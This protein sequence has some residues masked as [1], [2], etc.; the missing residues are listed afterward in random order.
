[1]VYKLGFGYND[2]SPYLRSRYTL[3]VRSENSTD[4]KEG[5]ANSVPPDKY[6]EVS[7]YLG[8]IR[9]APKTAF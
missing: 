6:G 3:E 5:F 9:Y 4:Q 1:M 8:T 7:E 2:K